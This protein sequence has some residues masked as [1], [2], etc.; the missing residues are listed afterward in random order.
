MI[1][2]LDDNINSSKNIDDLLDIRKDKKE[3]NKNFSVMVKRNQDI[4]NISNNYLGSILECGTFLEYI[5]DC[6][7]EHYKLT[8]ANFCKHRFC[9]HCSYNKSIKDAI[10]LSILVEYIK[11]QGYKFIFLTLTAPNVKS[12]DLEKELRAYSLAFNEMFKIKDIKKVSKGY[13]RK[14]E[15]TYNVEKDSYHPHYHIL[16]AVNK[17]YFTDKKIYLSRDKWLNLWKKYKHDDTITQIDI[18]KFDDKC[19][20][21]IFEITK[22]I[23]KDSNYLISNE[24]FITFYKALKGKRSYSFSGLFKDAKKMYKD[25]KLD[26]LKDNDEI[27]YIY[28]LWYVWDKLKYR[29]ENMVELTP[30]EYEKYN[31]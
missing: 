28:K 22:Y 15:L 11:S 29:K 25:G 3:K 5:S 16:I 1:P 27:E 19:D 2:N 18:R 30:E 4:I 9:P 23:A 12:S 6:N 24:V 13:V 8:N 10:E 17:S 14:L 31:N 26:Y 7:L 20:N 21:A